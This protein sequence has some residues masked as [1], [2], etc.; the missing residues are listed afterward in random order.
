MVCPPSKILPVRA[1]VLGQSTDPDHTGIRPSYPKPY[2]HSG[3]H[4]RAAYNRR[5]FLMGFSS[6]HGYNPL[7][8]P[9]IPILNQYIVSLI[10]KAPYLIVSAGI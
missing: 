4:R 3:I 1:S 7:N 9:A 8:F 2:R 6:A 10:P 5:T